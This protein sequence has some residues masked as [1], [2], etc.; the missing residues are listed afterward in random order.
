MAR[1][2]EEMQDIALYHME[3]SNRRNKRDENA[4]E[5]LEEGLKRLEKHNSMTP[6]ERQKAKTWGE[7]CDGLQEFMLKNKTWS[8]KN[9]SFVST[10][11]GKE[12]AQLHSDGV[13]YREVVA[14]IEEKA[15]ERLNW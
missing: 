14:F 1:S 13:T 9:F 7:W 12:M 4:P 10:K 11:Y 6:E 5:S 15:I 2:R 3:K 8:Q